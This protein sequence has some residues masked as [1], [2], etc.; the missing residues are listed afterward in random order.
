MAV[1][2]R[3]WSP[4]SPLATTKEDWEYKQELNFKN[5]LLNSIISAATRHD[6]D[7]VG[8]CCCNCVETILIMYYAQIAKIVLPYA[9]KDMATVVHPVVSF[10][11]ER[12][13]PRGTRARN[14][15]YP[16]DLN[17]RSRHGNEQ[18]TNTIHEPVHPA[19]NFELSLDPVPERASSAEA[20]Q[21][22]WP[23]DQFEND[24][25]SKCSGWFA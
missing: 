6:W 9:G 24:H 18:L 12:M 25:S 14:I 2:Q 3:R 11:D 5:G 21:A 19:S 8:S 16:G 4:T 1:N 22:T 23:S 15:E 10:E 17:I 13:S 7:A 20:G